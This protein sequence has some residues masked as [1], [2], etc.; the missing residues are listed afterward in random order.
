MYNS[1][2]SFIHSLYDTDE[3]VPLHSPLFIGNEKRYLSE[4]I[5][6]TFVSSVGQFVD[7][8]EKDIAIYTG[9]KKAVVCV[10]G[11]NALHMAML[12][13]G[14]EREDEILTQA[15]TFIATCNAISYIGAHPVFIDVDKVT[16]GLSPKAVSTWLEGNAELKNGVCDNT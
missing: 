16:L 5:D 13:V 9:A 3:F 7:R 2:V 15:L 10:S 1:I 6:T 12:L 14:V 11:T 8:F 4:C